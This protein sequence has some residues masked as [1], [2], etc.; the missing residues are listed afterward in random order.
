MK[1]PVDLRKLRTDDLPSISTQSDESSVFLPLFGRIPSR[2]PTGGTADR[3]GIREVEALLERM[4]SRKEPP[5]EFHLSAHLLPPVHYH[6]GPEQA[7]VQQRIEEVTR[8][9]TMQK[10]VCPPTKRP[11]PTHLFSVSRSVKVLQQRM[12]RESHRREITFS[13][14][15]EIEIKVL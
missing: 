10:S 1:E 3:R 13:D 14:G 7:F 2:Q 4:T 15:P 9:R 8:D 5:A 11:F 12:A 6:Y